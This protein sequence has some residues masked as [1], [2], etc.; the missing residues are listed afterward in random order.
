LGGGLV[1][2]RLGARAKT[3]GLWSGGGATHGLGLF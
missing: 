1:G 3:S 2:L